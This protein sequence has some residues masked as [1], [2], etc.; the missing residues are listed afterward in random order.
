MLKK[1]IQGLPNTP[2]RHDSI[3][4]IHGYAIPYLTIDPVLHCNLD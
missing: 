2:W 1:F 3:A 4:L